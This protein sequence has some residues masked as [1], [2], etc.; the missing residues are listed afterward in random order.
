ML[1]TTLLLNLLLL[2]KA[3]ADAKFSPKH[4]L[5]RDLENL[6]EKLVESRLRDLETR[7]QEDKE[8]QAT[9]EKKLE[10]KIKELEKNLETKNQEMKR[11]VQG[12]G[13]KIKEDELEASYMMFVILCTPMPKVP[14]FATNIVSQQTAQINIEEYLELG[15]MYWA[16]GMA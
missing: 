9:E 1:L 8:R 2:S 5:E 12:L 15:R 4:E 14:K 13:E 3:G 6:V 11:R 10:A 7:M 16:F